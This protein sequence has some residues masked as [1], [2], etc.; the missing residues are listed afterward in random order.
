MVDIKELEKRA[1]EIHKRSIVVDGHCHLTKELIGKRDQGERRVFK[2]YYLPLFNRVGLKVLLL[3]I[4]G[5]NN[6]NV[7]GSD[8]MLW[9]ALEVI[10]YRKKSRIFELRERPVRIRSV[11]SSYII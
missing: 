4:G 6:A 10:D 11:S 9:G 8:L 7:K 3:I 1:L 2:N 5:D